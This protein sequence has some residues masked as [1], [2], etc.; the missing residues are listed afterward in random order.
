MRSP[1]PVA[2][3]IRIGIIDDHAVIR[4]ALR[5]LI[6]ESPTMK[7]V[8]E[9]G[10]AAEALAMVASK[11]PDIIL[12]DLDL[13]PDDGLALLPKLLEVASHA[14]VLVLTGTHDTAAY[15]Q[16][17]HLGAMGLVHKKKTAGV[18]LKA[19]EKVN[20]GE[21]W[22]DRSLVQS[23][24]AEITR[25]G[26]PKQS[27]PEAGN[28][29]TLT[30]REREV[31]ALVGEGLKNKQLAERLFISETTIAHHLTSIYGKLHVSDRLELLIYAYSH[32]LAKLPTQAH[33]REA[34]SS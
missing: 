16:A 2:N 22:F 14:R 3:S 15:R 25:S 12:L 4:E 9:A 5:A 34:S 24:L 20:A 6:E 11:Q 23:M 28:I 17:A 33:P 7:I 31:I 27:D 18:L 21:I 32:H 19:I 8:G 29:A 30:E 13:D 26:E 10:D 1:S